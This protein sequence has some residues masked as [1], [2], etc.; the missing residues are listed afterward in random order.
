MTSCDSTSSAADESADLEARCRI[1]A[2]QQFPTRDPA[3]DQWRRLGKYGDLLCFAQEGQ[4]LGKVRLP[5]GAT[6]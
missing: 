6:E 4:Y 5:F 2:D 3:L 1:K